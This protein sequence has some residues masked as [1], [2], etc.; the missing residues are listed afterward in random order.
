MKKIISMLLTAV[1]CCGLL[2]GCA[3]KPKE[4][5]Q[6]VYDLGMEASGVL[7]YYIQEKM[8]QGTAANKL[9][10]LGDRADELEENIK[11]E[12]ET[13][14]QEFNIF[15]DISSAYSAVEFAENGETYKAE[16]CLKDLKDD[17][18]LK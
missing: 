18:N 10:E 4:V 17:L 3:G 13:T 12:R 6:E 1:I 14:I 8:S 9:D 2:V 7:E 5:S 15:L 11:K 16:E